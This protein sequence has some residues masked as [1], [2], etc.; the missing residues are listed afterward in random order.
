MASSISTSNVTTNPVTSGVWPQNNA[1]AGLG[2]N[3]N[4]ANQWATNPIDAAG[5]ANNLATQA[6]F[7]LTGGLGNLSNFGGLF[8]DGGCKYKDRSK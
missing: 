1:N 6:A 2:L 8:P 3:Y 4:G 7:G 5:L